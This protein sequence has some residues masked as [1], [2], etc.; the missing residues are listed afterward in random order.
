MTARKAWN[1]NFTGWILFTLSAIFF[2]WV[3]VEIVDWKSILA[4][5]FFLVA[6]VVFLVPVWKTRPARD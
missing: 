2:L 1:W 5:L 4:S 3:S 6:C